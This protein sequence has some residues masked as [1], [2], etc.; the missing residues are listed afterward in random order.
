MAQRWQELG[1]LGRFAVVTALGL[2]VWGIVLS[3]RVHILEEYINEELPA[4]TIPVENPTYRA[5]LIMSK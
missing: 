4:T 3:V 1:K 2:F 5:K